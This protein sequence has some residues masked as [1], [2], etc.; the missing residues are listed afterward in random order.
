MNVDGLKSDDEKNSRISVT[1]SEKKP[2]RVGFAGFRTQR[3]NHYTT[4]PHAK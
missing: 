3:D 4:K 1:I 2:C